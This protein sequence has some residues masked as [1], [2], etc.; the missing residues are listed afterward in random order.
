MLTC[1]DVDVSWW[2]G[3]YEGWWA[4]LPMAMPPYVPWEGSKCLPSALHH[5]PFLFSRSNQH[6]YSLWS[7]IF[8]YNRPE[9]CCF[10]VAETDAVYVHV[11]VALV[12][13]TDGGNVYVWVQWRMF[14][15][16][17]K[18]LKRQISHRSLLLIWISIWIMTHERIFPIF[19]VL[20]SPPWMARRSFVVIFFRFSFSH[21]LCV[22]WHSIIV[23]FW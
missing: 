21:S 11:N 19:P 12:W 6:Q 17:M 10:C 9:G 13:S 22:E 15:N 16:P 20:R 8:K 3:L 7:Y 5:H 2:G 23:V 1:M 18:S 4:Q 14:L